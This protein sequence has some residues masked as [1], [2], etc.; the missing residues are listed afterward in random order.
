MSKIRVAIAGYGNLGRGTELAVTNAV[1][2]ELVCVFTRRDPG[3]IKTKSGVPVYSLDDAVNM[4]DKI[5]VV[6]L[7]G[8]SATDLP[9]QTP[10]LA[11]YFNVV[12]SFDTHAKIPQHFE[13]VDKASK[14]GERVSLISIGWDPGLFSL[15]RLLGEAIL[16]NGKGYTFWGKGVSQGHSD[17]IRRI[18]GV[19]DARQYTVPIDS[20]VERVRSGENPELSVREKHT[21]ECF[22]VAEE[23]ADLEYIEKTIK[24]MPNYFADYNTTVTFITEEELKKN[25]SGIPH[26]GMVMTSGATGENKHLIEFKLNL[27]SNPEFTS[28]V[29][30]AYARAAY[31]L[32]N[33]GAY[34]C[35]TIFDVP[36]AYMH[37]EDSDTLRKKLL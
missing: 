30:T 7:C 13:N 2:M 35:K 29:L 4:Q 27:D 26:G 28:S 8:G 34:G 21:R 33:D 5:D 32:C 1:D 6:V 31:R 22:V 23:N 24:E 16:P 17:A 18:E 37:P 9:V 14:E 36:P 25:H 12:D 15:N 11:K 10:E 20:A 19:K 3:S